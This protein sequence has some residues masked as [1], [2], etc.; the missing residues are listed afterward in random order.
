MWPVVMKDQ[1]R[2]LTLLPPNLPRHEHR[3]ARAV[4]LVAEVL[5]LQR[6][7]RGREPQVDL[8][9]R[10]HLCVGQ[11]RGLHG[12]ERPLDLAD[13]RVALR[14]EQRPVLLPVGASLLPL[15]E[16]PKDDACGFA[17]ACEMRFQR[18]PRNLI[19]STLGKLPDLPM[20]KTL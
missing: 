11:H 8:E 15:L 16:H 6:G 14:D 2:L 3:P 1:S 9:H 18:L 20:T 17:G 19:I 12:T 13:Q 7:G 10:R 4:R 5:G